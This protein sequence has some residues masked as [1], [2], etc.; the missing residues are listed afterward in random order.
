MKIALKSALAAFALA[1]AAVPAAAQDL[2]QLIAS[3][4]LSRSEAVGMTLSQIAAHKFNRDESGADRQTIPGSVAVSVSTAG[5]ATFARNVG[6]STRGMP[7][8]SL[9]VLAARH[10]NRGVSGADKQ[11]E[12]RPVPGAGS[13]RAQLAASAGLDGPEGRTLTEIAGHFFNRGVSG[14]DKQTI[15]R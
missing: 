4:G 11:T 3:A 10:F 9:R 5:T 6:L 13:D 1:A 12:I 15:K 7:A 14:A 8:P 2:D